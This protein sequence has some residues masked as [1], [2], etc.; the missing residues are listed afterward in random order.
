MRRF[1][2]LLCT[3]CVM[4]GCASDADRAAWQAALKDAR[5]DNMVMK[6][7][8]GGPKGWEGQAAPPRPTN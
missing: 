8:F 7:D 2:L 5:G 1:G 6:S 3:L 4:C